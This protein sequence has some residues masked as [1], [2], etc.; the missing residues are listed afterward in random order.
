V[1]SQSVEN[2]LLWVRSQHSRRSIPLLSRRTE[3][4]FEELASCEETV[5]RG[6]VVVVLGSVNEG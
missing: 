3:A 4:S 1:G 6:Q 2:S 5:E